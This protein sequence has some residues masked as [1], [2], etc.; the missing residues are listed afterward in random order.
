[1]SLYIPL[2]YGIN[3]YSTKSD[4]LSALDWTRSRIG[5]AHKLAKALYTLW[6]ILFTAVKKL[7]SLLNGGRCVFAFLD[8][9]VNYHGEHMYTFLSFI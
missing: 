7:I 3:D 4:I 9:P 2:V 8:K 1:M 5:Y 6:H